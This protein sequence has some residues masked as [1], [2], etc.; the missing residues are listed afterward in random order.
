MQDRFES[1]IVDEMDEKFPEIDHRLLGR[2]KGFSQNKG[3]F[4]Y[5]YGTAKILRS[6]SS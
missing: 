4:I 1:L 5:L 3:T 2:N 6:Q